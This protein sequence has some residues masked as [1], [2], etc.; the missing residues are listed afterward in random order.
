MKFTIN[1]KNLLEGVSKCNS[2]ASRT[3]DVL[4]LKNILLR[5]LDG[6]KLMLTASSRSV[7]LIAEYEAEIIEHGS[8][9][10]H[11]RKL[12]ELLQ[13]IQGDIVLVE[14]NENCRVKISSGAVFYNLYGLS[15][16][17]YPK[18]VSALDKADFHEMKSELLA[19]M[20]ARTSHAMSRDESRINMNGVFIETLPGD[21]IIRTVATDGHRL[22][23]A[24]IESD[25]PFPLEKGI[26]IPRDGVSEIRKAVGKVTGNIM[27]GFSM[28]RLIV[29]ARDIVLW[30]SAVDAQYPDYR[31]VIPSNGGTEVKVNRSV[32]LQSLR[33][34]DVV[35]S[36]RYNAVVIQVTPGKMLLKS[37]NPD[38]GEA[39][40]EIEASCDKEASASFNVKYLIDA[41]DAAEGETVALCIRSN[42]TPASIK[43]CE[44]DNA[45][46]VIMPLAK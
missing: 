31:R 18:V 35:S 9:T 28:N 19:E 42:R 2:V 37:A 43:P 32:I 27:V 12:M 23:Y 11:P 4:I 15:A 39:E 34:M 6:G 29:K 10:I 3:T 30:V 13:E 22:A 26:I 7:G 40:D 33:R 41:I 45:L 44:T 14:S 25:I 38:V 8:V 5:T 16:E 17:D 46:Y 1:R 20:I 36:E 21:R 24:D